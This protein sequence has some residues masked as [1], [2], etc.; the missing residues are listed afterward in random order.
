MSRTYDK[1][2]SSFLSQYNSRIPM[3]MSYTDDRKKMTQ[4]VDL[5][6]SIDLVRADQVNM[7]G[8][9]K[10]HVASMMGRFNNAS[11]SRRIAQTGTT[12]S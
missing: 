12:K 2:D 6:D 4:S 8:Q 10:A 9:A 7:T 1:Q 11:M 3:S 5:P